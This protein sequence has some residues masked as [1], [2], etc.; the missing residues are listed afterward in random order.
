MIYCCNF[1]RCHTVDE[2]LTFYLYSEWSGMKA[3]G[4]HF[5]STYLKDYLKTIADLNV[6]SA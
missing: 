4:E 2:N 6:V 1:G 3:V 5:N